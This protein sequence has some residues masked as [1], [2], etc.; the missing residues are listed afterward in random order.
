V[1]DPADRRQYPRLQAPV[2][3]RP[4]GKPLFGRRKAID[5]S[6]GG[7]RL[8]A[9][10]APNP[11]ERLELELF[12]PDHSELTCR[13]EVVWVEPLGMGAPARFD[14][15]VKFVGISPVDEQRLASVLAPP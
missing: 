7:V 8:Y 12:L 14:V 15:G 1:A 13:V 5:I 4:L 9:D 3:C 11:G 2:F 6:L 10:E